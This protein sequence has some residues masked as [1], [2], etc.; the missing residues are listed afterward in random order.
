M[1][2]EDADGIDHHVDS[3]QRRPQR[4]AVDVGQVEPHGIET[5]PAPRGRVD[6]PDPEERRVS[7]SQQSA[8][9]RAS[10]RPA[11][12]GDEDAHQ[13]SRREGWRGVLWH[14]LSSGAVASLMCTA[15]VSALGRRGTGTAFSATNATSHWIW[16]TPARFARRGSLRHTVVGY[17]IHHASSVW[18][19]LLFERVT[20]ESRGSGAIAARAG[21]VA[22]LAYVVDYHVV[23]K[24]LTPGFESHLRARDMLAGYAAFAAG[25]WLARV[26]RERRFSPH[27]QDP[28]AVPPARAATRPARASRRRAPRA[29][30]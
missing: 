14:A 5:R 1:F 29:P 28:R 16:G 20:R 19:A 11:R 13:L 27:S 18:W 2:A 23:P 24:R 6:V 4:I 3:G 8:H 12:T 15:V 9:Q 22:T 26:A 30:G 21:A 10:D 25:L 17:A 7:M